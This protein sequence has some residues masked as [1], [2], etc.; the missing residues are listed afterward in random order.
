ME[1]YLLRHGQSESNARWE[2]DPDT[3]FHIPDPALTPIGAL[4]AEAAAVFLAQSNA[5][6]PIRN[7]DPGNRRGFGITHIYSSLMQRAVQTAMPIGQALKLPVIGR[8]D[9][10]EWGGLYTVNPA[11]EERTG[12]SGKSRASLEAAYP[13]LQLGTEI[14]A[15]GWWDRPYEPRSEVPAR[16]RRVLD[17]LLERHGGTDD[18]V[19]L[20]THGGFLNI[21]VSL[22]LNIPTET[23][24]NNLDQNIWLVTPN[25]GILRLDMVDGFTGVVYTGRIDHL[26]DHLIT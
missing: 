4:Q 2:E 25:T 21:F 12:L 15:D 26:P 23:T 9:L 14:K 1:I 11:T 18:R 13:G 16:A 7:H 20:V 22:V 3:P 8:D 10:H 5:R 19:L 17:N 24:I 6:A